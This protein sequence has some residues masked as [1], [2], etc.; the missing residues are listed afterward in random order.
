MNTKTLPKIGEFIEAEGGYFGGTILAYG[1]RLGII[2][3]PKS[4][5]ETTA[6]WLPGYTGVSGAASCFNS[7]AN[8][9]AM[10]EAGSPLAAW[11]TG[12]QINGH[13]DWVIPARDVLEL[14]YR[15]LKPTTT[16]TYCS[17]R[18]G[19]N[20][21]S[22]PVG[23]P[24]TKATPTVQTSAE[25]FKSGGAEAFEAC[26][27]WASTQYSDDYAWC[28]YFLNGYQSNCVKSAELRAR[29]VRLIQLNP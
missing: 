29:A 25:A 4:E 7:V 9:L 24:Y 16:E 14:G 10:A 11:A 19:D 15:H 12:L 2:W 8:T 28:Q 1:M 26:A 5:G 3:A 23:Y 18:D 20:P 6:I 27:Y 17:F 13:N 22:L 21:S